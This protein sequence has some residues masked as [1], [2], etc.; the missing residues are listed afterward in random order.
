MRLGTK[1]GVVLHDIVLDGDAAPPLKGHTPNFRPFSVVAKRLHDG[2]RCHLVWRYTSAQATLCSV[3][4]QL[5]PEK[6]H[7]HPH[8]IFGP[9]LLWPKGWIDEHASWYGSRPRHR[10]RC[11]RRGPSQLS[12]K[13]AQHPPLFA[14]VYC[15]HGRPSQ[16][17]LSSCTKLQTVAQK[18]GTSWTTEGSRCDQHH[19]I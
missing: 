9:C 10:P 1:V 13:G 2:L 8:P 7:P 19:R 18:G 5:P 6:R 17:L 15:G 4:T 16:L 11:I 14:Q 3:G 12:T